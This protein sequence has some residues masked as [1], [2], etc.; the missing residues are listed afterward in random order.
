MN[1]AVCF[2][3]SSEEAVASTKITNFPQA[4]LILNRDE[5]IT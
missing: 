5:K 2:D 3:S 4:L 1:Y